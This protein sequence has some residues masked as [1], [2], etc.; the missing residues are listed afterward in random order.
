MVKLLAGWAST[1]SRGSPAQNNGLVVGVD[2]DFY[3]VRNGV[4]KEWVRLV[5]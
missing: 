1:E 3:A 2:A 4:K 5:A